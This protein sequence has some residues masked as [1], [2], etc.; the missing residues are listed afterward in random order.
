MC[1]D[2]SGDMQSDFRTVLNS[3]RMG[4][5]AVSDPGS[6]GYYQD[7]KRSS[8]EFDRKVRTVLRGLTVFFRHLEFLNVF[9]YGLFC[10]QYFCHKLMRWMVPFLLVSAFVSSG[11][12]AKGSLHTG[13]FA[14]SWRF[15]P[16]H[17]EDGD[18]QFLTV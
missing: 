18:G 17:W 9:R 2:F 7:V 10:Y 16:S 14:G 11:F 8:Q 6:T 4:L 5:R 13:V 15:M 1:E 12:L 3:I